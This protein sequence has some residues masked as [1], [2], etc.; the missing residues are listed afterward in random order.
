MPRALRIPTHRRPTTPGETLLEEFLVPLNITQ[1]DFAKRIGVSYPRLNEIIRG[2]RG[3]TPD[4]ALRFA[5]ATG[6]SAEFW[7]NLQRMVDLYDA[8]HSP[9]AKEIAKI[10]PLVIPRSRERRR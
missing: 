7:L 9:K 4:T 10:S 3:V 8:M 5:K 6:V 2:H 1:A